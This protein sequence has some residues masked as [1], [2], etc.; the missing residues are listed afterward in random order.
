MTFRGLEDL[1]RVDLQKEPFTSTALVIDKSIKDPK[2]GKNVAFVS[3]SPGGNIVIL[4][5]EGYDLNA[6]LVA[7]EES[8][9]ETLSARRVKVFK[10][11]TQK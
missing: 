3:Y 2:I 1:Q 5:K 10:A 7:G 9:G 4:F 11:V 8:V 6:I